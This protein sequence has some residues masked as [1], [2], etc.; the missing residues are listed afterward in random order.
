MII[1]LFFTRGIS[2]EIW[3]LSG[4]LYREKILY[5]QLLTSGVLCKVYWIT[6]GKDDYH[7]SLELKSKGL[8]NENIHVIGIPRYFKILEKFSFLYSLVIPF[9]HFKILKESHLFKTN[10]MDGS[11]AALI[12]KLLFQKPFILR[13][14]YTLSKSE[15]AQGK[16]KHVASMLVE[17]IMYSFSDWAI[18]TSLHDKFYVESSYRVK[19]LHVIPNYVDTKNFR[20]KNNP[21]RSNS[22]LYVGR[23]SPD[24]NLFNLIE[25]VSKVGFSLDIYGSG[26][27]KKELE[28]FSSSL[29]ANVKFHNPVPNSSL[30]DI[31]NNHS[32][33]VLVSPKEGMPKT[34]IEAMACGCVC[35]GT[36]V[37]GINEIIVDDLNGLL[38]DDISVDSV[39]K[40]LKEIKSKKYSDFI[41]LIEQSESF[42]HNNYSLNAVL[43][44]EAILLRSVAYANH[45]EE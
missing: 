37:E 23:L 14:G 28:F 27:L 26:P 36:N 41:N 19:R 18:V 32:F 12:A 7:L 33:Y 1:S 17:R 15:M 38:I 3:A 11:W 34:L 21:R 13:A 25:A 44:K 10:Q 24:K 20:N 5:E 4:L 8:L 6:Y 39:A 30:V 29:I 40:K 16:I 31:Y 9:L 43:R 22:L 42:A 35:I 45:T 2:L